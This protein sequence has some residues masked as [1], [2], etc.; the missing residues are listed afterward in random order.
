MKVTLGQ[1]LSSP[2]F[3]RRPNPISPYSVQSRVRRKPPHSNAKRHHL[4]PEAYLRR[5]AFDGKRIHVF[6]CERGVLRTDVPRNVAVESEFNTVNMRSG[7]KDR[8][9]EACLA[10][11]DDAALNALTKLE[12]G[13]DLSRSERWYIS[14]FMGYAYTR[15]RGF[16]NAVQSNIPEPID[17]S[18]EEHGFVDQQFA[19]A[20]STVSGIILDARTIENMVIE[21]VKNVASGAYE[22]GSMVAGAFELARYMFWSEWCVMEAPAE[23][24]F[25]TSDRPLAILRNE[26]WFGGDPF[27][28]GAMKVL[29]LSPQRALVV[30][31]APDERPI[32]HQMMSPEVIRITNAG[33]AFGYDRELIGRSKET[34]ERALSDALLLQCSFLRLAWRGVLRTSNSM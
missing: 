9:V 31:A 10:E 23:S 11:M 16:R 33:M 7:S 6:D 22:V 8:A 32:L 24:E 2:P 18:Q 28:L 30:R 34:I 4:V 15:G 19:A 5:F 1:K 29:P 21:S 17:Y 12:R 20:F 13:D 3:N 25:V 14:F 27:E 26:T